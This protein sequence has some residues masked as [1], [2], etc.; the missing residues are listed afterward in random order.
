VINSLRLQYDLPMS[1]TWAAQTAMERATGTVPSSGDGPA[2]ADLHQAVTPY[3]TQLGAAS[4][5]SRAKSETEPFIAGAANKMN[6]AI[7]DV[8]SP[9]AGVLGDAVGG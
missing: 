8:L 6:R 4:A 2:Q 7:S 5:R 1:D 9:L 3:S